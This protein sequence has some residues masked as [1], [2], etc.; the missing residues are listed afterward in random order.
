MEKNVAMCDICSFKSQDKNGECWGCGKK[1][2]Y[3]LVGLCNNCSLNAIPENCKKCKH[4]AYLYMNNLCWNCDNNLYLEEHKS[5]FKGDNISF[6]HSFP[7]ENYKQSC[8]Q[9]AKHKIVFSD[10]ENCLSC[11]VIK[12]LMRNRSMTIVH[13]NYDKYGMMKK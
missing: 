12:L 8:S 1:K 2:A 5:S 3:I 13:N 11:H 4:N 6:K 10:D 7:L 9:C